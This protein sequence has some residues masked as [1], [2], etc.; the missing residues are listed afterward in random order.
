[1]IWWLTAK[2]SS[3]RVTV[4]PF[5]ERLAAKASLDRTIELGG[6]GTFPC[7]IVCQVPIEEIVVTA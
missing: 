1:M 7:S 5:N 3:L 6:L 4:A 2:V